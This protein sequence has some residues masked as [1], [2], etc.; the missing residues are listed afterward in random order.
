MAS[1][2]LGFV[3][4]HFDVVS[5]RANHESR[6]VGRVV[7]RTQARR[8]IVFASRLQNRAMESFDLPAILGRERQ[9]KMRGLLVGLVEAQ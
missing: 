5:V 7:L 1:S 2:G 3:A 9:V 4:N 6:I 8:T